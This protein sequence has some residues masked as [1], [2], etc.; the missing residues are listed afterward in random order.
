MRQFQCI[1]TA[2]ATENK[3]NLKKK[4]LLPSI[5]SI[6]SSSFKHPKLQISIKMPVALLQ[7]VF[8]CMTATSHNKRS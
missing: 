6:V 2:Y 3:E 7:R 4:K 8:I 5:M 1:P